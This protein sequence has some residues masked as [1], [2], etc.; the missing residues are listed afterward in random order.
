MAPQEYI[1]FPMKIAL[2]WSTSNS[3]APL[4]CEGEPFLL[5][6]GSR[7]LLTFVSWNIARW[8]ARCK[9]YSCRSFIIK[10]EILLSQECWK[11][12]DHH[13]N[14][15]NSF[16][17]YMSYISKPTMVWPLTLE[18]NSSIVSENIEKTSWIGK[19]NTRGWCNKRRSTYSKAA[20]ATHRHGTDQEYNYALTSHYSH[21]SNRLN[22]HVLILA[23]EWEDNF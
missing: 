16:F 18:M 14:D 23:T 2:D 11:A 10:Y 15:Y 5:H 3:L 8:C 12:N 4:V 21:H 9:D 1:H 22:F 17:S 19:G 7:N 20:A 13:L 6:L